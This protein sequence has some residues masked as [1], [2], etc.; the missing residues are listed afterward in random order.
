LPGLEDRGVKKAAFY[1]LVGTTMPSVLCE[2]SFITRPEEAA[3]LA[4]DE[5][6][7]AL[8]E[9]IAQGIASYAKK[10]ALQRVK[11]AARAR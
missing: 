7:D 5:Y 10:A 6:R 11:A 3:A 8:A 4:T 2:A 9:G 1:V